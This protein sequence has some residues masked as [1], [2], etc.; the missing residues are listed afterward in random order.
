ML[1]GRGPLLQLHDGQEPEA[2]GGH[3]WPRGAA[4]QRN[5]GAVVGL[6]VE[7][8]IDVD[9]VDLAAQAGRV[10]V[11]GQERGH[12]QQVVAVDQPVGPVGR[13][14]L[15][16]VRPSVRRGDPVAVARVL[17]RQYPLARLQTDPVP[18]FQA[19]QDLLGLLPPAGDDLG[20]LFQQGL[21]HAIVPHD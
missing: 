12:R 17:R 18:P 8:W 10:F 1:H 11:A 13:A 6:G 14:F 7:R 2:P 15:A 21:G 3:G 16:Q 5:L 19:L 4:R 9:Q 20:E